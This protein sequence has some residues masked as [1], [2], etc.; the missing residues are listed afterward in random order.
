MID[1]VLSFLRQNV[2]SQMAVS[3]GGV[4]VPQPDELGWLVL[5]VVLAAC[6][7]IMPSLPGASYGASL[8]LILIFFVVSSFL[9]VSTINL[10]GFLVL[11]E[12]TALSA[13]GIGKLGLRGSNAVLGA[14][15]VNAVGG[16]SSLAMFA[17]VALLIVQNRSFEMGSLNTTSPS[18]LMALLLA[19]VILKAFGLLS[20]AWIQGHPATFPIGNALLASG[21]VTVVGMY[22]F[23]RFA[24]SL[25]R[26]S[27][28]ARY[29]SLWTS[30]VI[31]IVFAL[32]ALKELDLYRLTSLL[33]FS[34]FCLA[35]AGFSVFS[36][37]AAA[38]S[39]FAVVTYGFA[40]VMLFLSVGL[41]SEAFSS[42]NLGD[43]G[44]LMRSRPIMA[45]VLLVAILAAA[46]LPPFGTFVGRIMTGLAVFGQADRAV[47]VV[48]IASWTAIVM[49]LFRVLAAVLFPPIP[50]T[51]VE[52][53]RLYPIVTIVL[54]TS[55]LLA[56][57]IWPE[58]VLSLLEP[59]VSRIVG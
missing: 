13:W 10:V 7:L 38:S 52:R 18:L 59:A 44:G 22:P 8:F 50:P 23:L 42:R 46:G 11:W 49:A 27:G 29:L 37:Q 58:L 26:I 15:P 35:L 28:D 55:I 34:Q 12:F 57:A 3:A 53:L 30:L 51:R 48:W 24:G 19:A 39:L 2:A 33:A 9:L 47:G 43:L 41:T 32:A 25:M 56:S 31:A 21:A 36:Q 45:F 6:L 4:Q 16:L 14:L 54:G 17:F 1:V 5:C 20:S 40:V